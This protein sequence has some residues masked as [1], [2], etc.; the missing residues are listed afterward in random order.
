M[1]GEQEV[2]P[3]APKQ[4]GKST[5]VISGKA[6]FILTRFVQGTQWNEKEADHRL[7]QEEKPQPESGKRH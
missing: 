4:R 5:I 1:A 3:S 7:L 2:A 6:K